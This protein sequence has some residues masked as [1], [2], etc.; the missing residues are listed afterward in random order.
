MSTERVRRVDNRPEAAPKEM[1]VSF[2]D[3]LYPLVI[4]GDAV[5]ARDLLAGLEGKK[6]AEAKA[7]FTKASRW[8]PTIEA[9]AF[10]FRARDHHRDEAVRVMA[11]CAVGLCGPATAAKRVPWDR[12]WPHQHTAG[13]QLFLDAVCAKDPVWVADFVEA[14]SHRWGRTL[15]RV[16]RTINSRV[17]VPCP[18]GSGYT[19]GW[20][21]Y[22]PP[23]ELAQEI[24]DDPWMP[25]V[26]THILDFGSAADWENLPGALAILGTS[27]RLDRAEVV[28]HIL[29]LLTSPQKPRSQQALVRILA[30]FEVRDEELPGI[31]YVL[32]V[33][34]T[35]SG[36]VGK[37]LLPAAIRLVTP[38]DLPQ[39]VS[40]IASRSE[41]A[42]KAMLVEAL[43]DELVHRVGLDPVIEA[44]VVFV[45]EGDASI[46][47][48]A[49]TALAGLASSDVV[50]RE[51]DEMP[52]LG[53]W[54][55]TPQAPPPPD[56][57]VDESWVNWTLRS[58]AAGDRSSIAFQ[59]SM[60]QLEEHGDWLRPS[61]YAADMPE[62]FMNGAMSEAWPLALAMAD[63]CCTQLKRPA[64]LPQLLRVL[65]QFA[66]EAPPQE[67][68]QNLARLAAS[69]GS[70]KAQMESR[71]LGAAMARTDLDAYV[72]SLH[73]HVVPDASVHA[74]PLA[75][76]LER[77]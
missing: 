68:P 27:G 75:T 11:L 50:A 65:V 9:R 26:L 51:A 34:A 56:P 2:V 19:P 21:G 35:N 33:M 32:G 44:L 73:A 57:G 39:L 60:L 76:A 67:L 5:G 62:L 31:D 45:G 7:W 12:F 64:A 59:W 37:Y 25:D 74:G 42:Q 53:L 17:P 13:D 52:I 14:A 4:A 69:N 38:D 36:A 63:L 58:L 28:N 6:L 10:D 61:R 47:G 30:A 22:S 66:P 46:S 40:V 18:T 55:L 15:S 72:R 20:D 29:G 8:Y 48:R 43:G 70:A 16:L 23:E 1:F 54:D 49:K 77:S 3:S 24:A 41:K 71:A